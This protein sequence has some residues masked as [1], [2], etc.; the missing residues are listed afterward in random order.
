[1]FVK[2]MKPLRIFR[3]R[4]LILMFLTWILV[5][6]L[7]DSLKIGTTHDRLNMKK[8]YSL[9]WYNI[10]QDNKEVEKQMKRDKEMIRKVCNNNKSISISSTTFLQLN[11]R[12]AIDRYFLDSNNNIGYCI[13]AKVNTH[14]DFQ[15]NFY[16]KL[17]N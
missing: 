14:N 6:I 12:I 4:V 9:K 10:Q 15:N 1:M 7:F 2:L 5:L 13:N 17:L 8:N 16:L 3:K 11:P